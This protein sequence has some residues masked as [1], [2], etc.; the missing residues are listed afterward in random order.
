MPVKPFAIVAAFPTLEEAHMARNLLEVHGIRSVVDE[1]AHGATGNLSR[2]GIRL[3]VEPERAPLV[4]SLLPNK[5]RLIETAPEPVDAVASQATGDRSLDPGFDA[6]PGPSL[7]AVVL[8]LTIT[9][10]LA[11]AWTVVMLIVM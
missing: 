5:D 3:L 9:L 2:S 11:L 6:S 1:Y 8:L 10:L 7:A 4:R